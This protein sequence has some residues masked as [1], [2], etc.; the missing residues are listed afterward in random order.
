VLRIEELE[1]SEPTDDEI[2]IEV[3][4]ASV[5]PLDWHFMRGT[6][7][8]MR[9]QSGLR[10]PRLTRLGVD[11]AGR[12]ARVGRRITQFAV[13]DAVFGTARGSFAEFVCGS[14]RTLVR[15]PDDVPFEEAAA[16]GVAAVTAL[17]ALRDKART[18]AGER[19]L[20]NGA[21]GGVGTFSVQIAK[22]LGAR[23]TAICSTRNLEMMRSI[24]A[25]EA[26]DYTTDDFT[27]GHGRFDV[28]VDMI[29]GH[30]LRAC[31]RAL[32]ANGRY[33][34]VG[35][36]RGDWIAP[37]DRALGAAVLSRFVV[38]ELGLLMVRANHD[39]FVTIAEW[40]ARGVVRAVIDRRYPLSEA[41]RAVEYVEAGHA[42]GKV[43]ITIR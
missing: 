9:L 8:L 4:A 27:A 29:G 41:S 24:G 12:V 32:T 42:R 28:I 1:V 5:N 11:V 13:G 26:L 21:S 30:P 33:V 34:I 40:L 17:Q 2:L 6:P 37:F 15:K 25:D 3:C 38:Q 23:V 18:Q 10:T 20:V 35:G 36:A 43:V 16:S 22:A 14:E 7:S 39:D 19:V 31:R